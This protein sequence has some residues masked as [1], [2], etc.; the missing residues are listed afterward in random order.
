MKI[1]QIRV[2]S[3]AISYLNS[4]VKVARKKF[5]KTFCGRNLRKRFCFRTATFN[6]GRFRTLK[7][8]WT[9]FIIIEE[10][11]AKNLAWKLRCG[12]CSRWKI[13]FNFNFELNICGNFT[14]YQLNWF[15]NETNKFKRFQLKLDWS[16]K[17][18]E[19]K[20]FCIPKSS[21]N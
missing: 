21:I 13:T 11:S 2:E 10:S 8:S 12:T 18:A 3:L 1:P 14:S 15:W 5:F 17:V 9:R 6:R 7:K 20:S 4:K 19:Q 16:W